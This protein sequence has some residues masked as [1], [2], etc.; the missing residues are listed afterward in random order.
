MVSFVI[1]VRPS[2]A[3]CYD[4]SY[5]WNRVAINYKDVIIFSSS[6]YICPSKNSIIASNNR[7]CQGHMCQPD[8]SRCRRALQLCWRRRS[9]RSVYV[10][11]LRFGLN[12][13][14]VDKIHVWFF[15]SSHSHPAFVLPCIFI[16]GATIQIGRAQE[17]CEGYICEPGNVKVTCTKKE[18][19]AMEDLRVCAAEVR[20]YT[21]HCWQGNRWTP[22][23]MS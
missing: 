12:R 9:C 15:F 13:S 3:C 21:G 4:A 10:L 18:N 8:Q 2:A 6:F 17:C 5:C 7:K 19:V 11:S 23:I 20:P 16:G 14:F 1:Q 22:R